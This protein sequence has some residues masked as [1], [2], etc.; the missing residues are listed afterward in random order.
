MVLPH[1]AV[2]GSAKTS[3][4]LASAA[5]LNC[6]TGGAGALRRGWG[7]GF[8]VLRSCAGRAH[9]PGGLPE[10]ARG[11]V[12]GECPLQLGQGLA[13]RHGALLVAAWGCV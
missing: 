2:S 11:G 10:Q 9:R 7:S 6:G 1:P 8:R 3:L 12:G 5:V 13:N 4:A